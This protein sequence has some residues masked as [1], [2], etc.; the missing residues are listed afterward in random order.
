M[1]PRDLSI[2]VGFLGALVLS[3][4]VATRSGLLFFLIIISPSPRIPFDELPSQQHRTVC[5]DMSYAP[6][7]IFTIY[8]EPTQAKVVIGV[9]NILVHRPKD[10]VQRTSVVDKA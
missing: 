7:Q 3:I 2:S 9:Q 10:H 4:L 6:W 1:H 5:P 8:C